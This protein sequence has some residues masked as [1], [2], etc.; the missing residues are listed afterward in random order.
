LLALAG[1][2]FVPA[3]PGTAA[4]HPRGVMRLAPVGRT[5]PIPIPQ[6]FVNTAPAHLNYYGGPIMPFTE[7]AIV[8]WGGTGHTS[9]LTSGLPDFF[10]A[11]A[12]AGNVNTYNTA[13]EYQ[14]Q[15]P[16]G[17]TTN[18]PLTLASQYLGS[19]TISPSTPST[20]LT[21]SD[22][23]AQLTS[24]IAAGAL[25]SPRVAFG[26]PVTEYY[27]MF[28]P[29]YKICLGTDC[30]NV[31]FC[32]YHSNAS[33]AGTP[34]TYTVL[35]EST[36]T[37][38]GC[39]ASSGGDGFGNLTSMTSHEMVESITDPEVGSATD[40]FP[41][42][43]WY[44][45]VN[46]EVAD[47]CNGQEA[48]LT[49]GATSWIVQKQWSNTE[50]A[51]ITSHVPS[52]LKGVLADFT[53]STTAGG[54]AGF[55]GSITTSPNGT[56]VIANYAWDWGDGTSSSGSSPTVA[57][58]YATPG[59]RMVTMIATDAAG[60][61]GAKFLSATTRNLTVNTAGSGQVRSGPAGI[62]CG[63]ACAAN[64]L[65]GATVS[66][67]ADAT[68]GGAFV[69]WTGDCAGQ[70][71]TCVLPMTAAR[72][73]TATFTSG[74]PP[75]PPSPP[76]PSPPPPS[77]PPPPACVVPAVRGQTLA[78]ARTNFATAHCSAGA[79]TRRYSRTVRI[80][81]VISQGVAAGTQL[82]D[83]AAVA[84]VVSKGRA[85]AKVTL[86]YR[87]QTVHVTRAVARRLLRHGARLG[88]CSRRR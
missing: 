58:A 77:P 87:H 63:G 73:A 75:P 86:C 21:D 16:G 2:V 78:T 14:T 29:T 33:Y 15:G 72:N 24:Q 74:S 42:L 8:L 69:G 17:T 45:A 11:F 68:S 19:F 20:K 80:G 34:F 32:A 28:P 61:S 71:A 57:H 84:L 3:A 22:V 49:L 13:L 23:A 83:G 5:V 25:P 1:A 7:N 60:A 82:A 85:P 37:N 51:C 43:A 31:Q 26:G 44:D 10:S 39:G 53:P 55:D 36:P 50:T 54:P 81:R 47:I 41:P 70:P 6:P 48:T 30:S 4:A 40:L 64:F 46:G 76:S 88:P 9:T 38:P 67:T 52:G 65:D 35:P 18:Q 79:I 12:N 66:L 62:D 27:V 56:G 59:T